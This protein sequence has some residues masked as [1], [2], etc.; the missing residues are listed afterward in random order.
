M[1]TYRNASVYVNDVKAWIAQTATWETTAGGEQ[2]INDSSEA[3]RSIGPVTGTLSVEG[4]TPVAGSGIDFLG[5]HLRQESCKVMLATA[6]AKILSHERAKLVKLSVKSDTSKG[7]T[8]ITA[9]FEFGRTK[10][11]G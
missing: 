4:A 11:T 3:E 6:E 1:A 7:T 2:I 10:T 8:M 5:I 9:D